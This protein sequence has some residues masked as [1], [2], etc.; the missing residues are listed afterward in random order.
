MT[1]TKTRPAAK[2]DKRQ[3]TANGTLAAADVLTLAEAAA[4]LR[5]SAD[6]V[7]KMISAE[8]L[9]A[10]KLGTEWRFFKAAIQNWLS[11]PRKGSILDHAG[12]IADDPYLE[13]MLREIY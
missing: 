9:P 8:D 2:A 11:T 4:Y 1:R 12:E 5:V 10:R 7:L 3:H 6:D 13:E